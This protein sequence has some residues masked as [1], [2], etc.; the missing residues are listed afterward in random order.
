MKRLMHAVVATSTL[1]TL[2]LSMAARAEPIVIG[3][4]NFNESYVLAEIMAQL[5]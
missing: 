4:K 3:S 1:L 5:V 2:S